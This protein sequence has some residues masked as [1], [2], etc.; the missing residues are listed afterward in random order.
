MRRFFRFTLRDV[1]WLTVVVA[2]VL[3]WWIDSHQ[4]STNLDAERLRADD[5]QLQLRLT[6]ERVR[7]L[8]YLDPDHKPWP[9]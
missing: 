8:E 2:L 6:E 3:A 7:H 5:L 9:G 4:L 1:F